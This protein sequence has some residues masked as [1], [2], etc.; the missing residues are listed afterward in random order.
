MNIPPALHDDLIHYLLA[1]SEERPPII[2]ELARRNAP[3]A[4]LLVGLEAHAAV[5]ALFEAELLQTG[6]LS[7]SGAN[8]NRAEEEH[9]V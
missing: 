4:D 7:S 2:I 6:S 9:M 3:L 8:T 1:T 5:R